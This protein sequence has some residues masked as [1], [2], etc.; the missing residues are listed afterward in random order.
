MKVQ[1]LLRKAQSFVGLGLVAAV[2]LAPFGVYYL[3]GGEHAPT[4]PRLPAPVALIVLDGGVLQEV[5]LLVPSPVPGIARFPSDTALSMPRAGTLRASTVFEI[6]GPE[7]IASALENTVGVK[8][9]FW[10]QGEAKKISGLF[11]HDVESNLGSQLVEAREMWREGLKQSFTAEG[12]STVVGLTRTYVVNARAVRK[13]LR[14][15]SLRL[16]KPKP[17]PSLTAT[18]AIR[19]EVLRKLGATGAGT[20][21]GAQ[22]RKQGLTVTRVGDSNVRTRAGVT[23]VYYVRSRAQ[24]DA[25]ALATGIKGLKAQPLPKGLSTKADVLV[26]AGR[27]AL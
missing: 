20:A 9:P 25:V 13:V 19:V 27:D 23:S 17:T 18:A 7:A 14:T 4:A 24:G 2:A 26:L 3:A 8:V 6:V 21:M 5:G 15:P 12:E 22:L 16:A 1:F 10:I 11:D